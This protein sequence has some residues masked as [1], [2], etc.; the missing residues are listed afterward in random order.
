MIDNKVSDRFKTVR[1][2]LKISQQQFA[3]QL[4]TTQR[5][6][7]KYETGLTGVPDEIKEKLADIG[8]NLHWFVTGFGEMFISSKNEASPFRVVRPNDVKDSDFVIPFIDQKVSAGAGQELS[9][10]DQIRTFIRAPKFLSSY[11]RDVTALQVAGD[12][13]EPTLRDGDIVISDT[14]GWRKEGIY[15][16]QL[17]GES[18]VKR[19]SKRVKRYVIIS[20]NTAYPTI[21]EPF[22]SEWLRIIGIVHCA[23]RA[24]E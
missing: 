7:S 13:M 23:V 2:Y 22:E 11:G 20:D 4:G 6:I 8:I 10:S 1:E 19:L 21:E 14:L 15:V 24:M 12:S 16:I 3:L 9:E 17:H 18:F 5:N